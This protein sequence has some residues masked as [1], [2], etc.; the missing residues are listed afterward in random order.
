MATEANVPMRHVLPFRKKLSD[1]KAMLDRIETTLPTSKAAEEK[2]EEATVAA[3]RQQQQLLEEHGITEVH[4][5]EVDPEL[6]RALH[7]LKPLMAAKQFT[8]QMQRVS[9]F[10]LSH[11]FLLIILPLLAPGA[12]PEA[13]GSRRTH[14]RVG[15][16]NCEGSTASQS[17]R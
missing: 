2:D 5:S 10:L 6:V 8:S 12:K 15:S 1:Y 11:L 3:Q 7:E 17:C 9:P 13:S 4:E 14:G 16:R